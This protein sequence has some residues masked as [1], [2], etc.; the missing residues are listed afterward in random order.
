LP[1]SYPGP[2][3]LIYRQLKDALLSPY[4]SFFPL[5]SVVVVVVVV[6]VVTAS[7]LVFLPFLALSLSLSLCVAGRALEGEGNWAVKAMR[8]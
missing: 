5:C 1:L 7:P 2:A 4:L 6:V 8:F 3:E